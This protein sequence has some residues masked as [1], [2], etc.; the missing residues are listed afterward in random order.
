MIDLDKFKVLDRLLDKY[1]KWIDIPFS[2]S[3]EDSIQKRQTLES[4]MVPLEKDIW[5]DD[6]WKDREYIDKY[7]ELQDMK[8]ELDSLLRIKRYEPG[9]AYPE[10]HKFYELQ[11]KQTLLEENINKLES[12]I[13]EYKKEKPEN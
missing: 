6:S 9:I 5:G 13:E 12:E 8:D 1:R 3:D 2:F 11:W 10:G 7:D 4:E